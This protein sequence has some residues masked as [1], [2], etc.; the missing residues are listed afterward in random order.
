MTR[1][2]ELL[3]IGLSVVLVAFGVLLLVRVVTPEEPKFWLALLVTLLGVLALPTARLVGAGFAGVGVFMLLRDLGV[4]EVPWLGYGLSVFLIAVGV[5]GIATRR[6]AT[7][8]NPSVDA[9]TD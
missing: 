1:K 4:I 2:N 9:P 5:Y 6:Q 7:D 3:Q 8:E